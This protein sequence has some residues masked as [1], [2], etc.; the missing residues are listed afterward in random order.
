MATTENNFEVGIVG[1]S[2]AGLSL[3]HRLHRA[4]IPYVSLEWH[5]SAALMSAYGTVLRLKFANSGSAWFLR[6]FPTLDGQV[7][8]CQ[9]FR[10][11][12]LREIGNNADGAEL[13][14][15]PHGYN[16]LFG[17]RT[18]SL[19]VLYVRLEDRSR[20]NF[21]KNGTEVEHR[22]NA[23]V[24]RFA[25]GSS[26][27]GDLIVAAIEGSSKLRELM[28]EHVIS[29][30]KEDILKNDFKSLTVDFM[31][32]FGVADVRGIEDNR[33][34]PDY[35]TR[36]IRESVVSFAVCGRAGSVIGQGAN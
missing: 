22:D 2:Y 4:I 15:P 12:K 3:A 21:R 13:L 32:L 11:G 30:G 34:S 9:G 16:G 6:R 8:R 26:Y 35:V 1:S 10:D 33:L 20:V 19:Q 18:N 24:V 17:D 5:D 23:V 25:D 29:V 36:I 14:G 28:R 27:E 31:A 7:N